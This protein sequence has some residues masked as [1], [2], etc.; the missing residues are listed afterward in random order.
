MTNITEEQQQQDEGI[1]K[2][3]GAKAKEGVQTAAS[4]AGEKAGDLRQQAAGKVEEQIDQRSTEV[5]T[6]ARSVASALR[7]TTGRLREQGSSGAATVAE[8]ASDRIEQ[9]GDYLERMDGQSIMRDIQS[10]ARRRPWALAGIGVVTGLLGARF[11]KASGSS[12]SGGQM[13]SAEG[14]SGRLALPPAGTTSAP[15]DTGVYPPEP[16]LDEPPH[17]VGTLREPGDDSLSRDPLGPQ[18]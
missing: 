11:A 17:G 4:A 8:Q 5:G 6:Q 2:E 9:L 10:F 3:A 16:G 14:S 18:A 13:G 12:G 15:Y 7:D 1:V